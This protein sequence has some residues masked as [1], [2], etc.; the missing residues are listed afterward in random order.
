MPLPFDENQ[1]CDRIATSANGMDRLLPPLNKVTRQLNERP[2]ETL[3]F[4][5]RAEKFNATTG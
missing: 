4:E 2:R 1:W 3:Q 5:A